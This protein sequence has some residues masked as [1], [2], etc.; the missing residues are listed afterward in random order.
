[1][2]RRLSTPQASHTLYDEIAQAP[3]WGPDE[4]LNT[5]FDTNWPKKISDMIASSRADYGVIL[6]FDGVADSNGHIDQ[7]RSA[8]IIPCDW[9]FQSSQKNPHLL[10]GPSINPH[11]RDALDLLDQCIE[12]K[13][14]L[15]KWL[16]S[17]QNIDA[18]KKD[19]TKFYQKLADS[20][21]PLLIHVGTEGTFKSLTPQLNDAQYLCYPLEQGVKVIAAHSGCEPIW[22]KK[23]NY[24]FLDNL[25]HRFSNLWLDNSGL[26]NFTRF[27]HVPRLAKS[28]WSERIIYGSDWPVPVHA[29]F[30]LKDMGLNKVLEIEK[31]KNWINKDMA[32]K[33]FYGFPKET[34]TRAHQVLANLSYW[35]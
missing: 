11:R 19:L 5:N 23:T 7:N 22:S 24:I 21:I 34:Y 20:Q 16:P 13:A 9:V 28:P 17:V 31:E 3:S 26:C 32:I 27:H 35:L 14:V 2:P 4:D 25:L 18:S 1:M 8:L 15:I 30:F 10:P 6:G 33:D 12:K 29:W